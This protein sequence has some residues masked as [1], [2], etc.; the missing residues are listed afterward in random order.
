[1]DFRSKESTEKNGGSGIT[2]SCFTAIM[3]VAI[4]G[5][6]S[7]YRDKGYRVFELGLYENKRLLG[8]QKCTF[9]S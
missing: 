2:P 7:Q 5:H 1:M 9:K 6:F 8:H 3:N 4:F